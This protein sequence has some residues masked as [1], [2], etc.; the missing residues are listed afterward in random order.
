VGPENNLRYLNC[1]GD[2][3]N[4]K[5]ALPVELYQLNIPFLYPNNIPWFIRVCGSCQANGE[6]QSLIFEKNQLIFEKV[7]GGP[8]SV[9][10]W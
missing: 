2:G 6:S 10:S 7:N 8:V 4:N 3:Q 1:S 9:V 5:G